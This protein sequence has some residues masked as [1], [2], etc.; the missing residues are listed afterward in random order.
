MPGNMRA[1]LPFDDLNLAFL[2]AL[3]TPNGFPIWAANELGF[4]QMEG[5]DQPSRAT[6]REHQTS[7][8]GRD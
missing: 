8:L 6:N 1:Q 5:L 7:P 2:A 4:Y 3:S